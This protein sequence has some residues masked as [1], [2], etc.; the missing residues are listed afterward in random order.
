MAR[1]GGHKALPTGLGKTVACFDDVIVID[2]DPTAH[3]LNMPNCVFT[4]LHKNNIVQQLPSK[5]GLDAAGGTFSGADGPPSSADVPDFKNASVL[6][7]VA[8]PPSFKHLHFQLDDNYIILMSFC[9]PDMA[10]PVR[11]SNLPSQGPCCIGTVV[12]RGHDHVSA[13]CRD[14]GCFTNNGVSRF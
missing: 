5:V 4:R 6:A 3:V 9:V 1:Q 10:K 13:G 14:F 8:M 12:S 7:N 2:V 11:P